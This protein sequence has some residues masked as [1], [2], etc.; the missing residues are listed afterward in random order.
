MLQGIGGIVSRPTVQRGVRDRT[1]EIAA[2][3]LRHG[4]VLYRADGGMRG[5]DAGEQAGAGPMQPGNEYETAARRAHPVFL[6]ASAPS[7]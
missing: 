5:N 2:L 6:N 7:E 1:L 4:S 3:A